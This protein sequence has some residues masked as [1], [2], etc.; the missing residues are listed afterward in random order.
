MGERA[1]AC[2][3]ETVDVPIQCEKCRDN[4]ADRELIVSGRVVY[5]CGSCAGL[6]LQLME[7]LDET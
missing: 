1:L 5:V 2:K 4:Q 3:A 6:I 7:F